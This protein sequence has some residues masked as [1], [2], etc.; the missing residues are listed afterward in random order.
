MSSKIDIEGYIDGSSIDRRLKGR[1][2]LVTGGSRG[3]GAA[4]ATAL[5]R[6]GCDVAIGYHT[7]EAQAEA[8]VQ[9]IEAS[10]S[11]CRKFG[12]DLADDDQLVDFV[13]RIQD[14]G[15]P[16]DILL[17][18]AGQ[19]VRPGDW[20][21]TQRSDL[22]RTLAVNLSSVVQ[23]IQL[24][25]PSMAVRGWGRIINM[26][27]TYATTGAAAVLAYTSAKAGLVP[28]TYAL[29][30]ELGPSGVTVNAIAPGNIL[31][32]MTEAAGREF[33]ETVASATPLK[34]LGR[35]EEIGEAVVFLASSEFITGHVLVVDGGHLLNM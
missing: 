23:L 7:R 16:V 27:S 35:P 15:G 17:N 22:N 25:A 14:W 2:A 28:L 1:F 3:I 8:I 18:N 4:S 13:R 9:E 11:R 26:T 20:R 24:L 34:R 32:D 12:C 6:A 21:S 30:R 33:M 19:I 31:T 29:A 10:G 5:A